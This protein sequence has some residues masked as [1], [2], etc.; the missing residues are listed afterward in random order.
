L[1]YRFASGEDFAPSL[2]SVVNTKGL[3]PWILNWWGEEFFLFLGL[4]GC[5]V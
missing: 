4:V 3:A 2:C 1:T 5:R